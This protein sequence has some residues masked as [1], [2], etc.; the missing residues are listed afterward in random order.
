MWIKRSCGDRLENLASSRPVVLVTGAR[1]T[2]KSSL[3]K[4]R[5]PSLQYLTFDHLRQVE[6][7]QESPGLFLDQFNGPAVLDEIQYVP[8]L[9]KEI[10]PRVDLDRQSYGRWILTGSQRFELMENISESL[11]GRISIVNLETLSASELRGSQGLAVH[12]HLWKGG[13]PELWSNEN[14]EVDDFFESYLRTYVERDLKQII[15]VKNLSDF[16]RFMKI[17]AARTGQLLNYRDMANDVGI[18]D[19]TIKTWVHALQMSGLVYLLPPF[20]ANIGKRLTKSPKLYFADHGL[21]CYLLGINSADKWHSHIYRGNLWETFVLM[22]V[23]KTSSLVPG[24]ELFFYRDHNGVEIDF[25][26]EKGDDLT[27][28]EAKVGERIDPGKLNFRKVAPL[29]STGR[30]LKMIVAHN[31]GDHKPLPQKGYLSFNPLNSEPPI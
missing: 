16:R 23:V 26:V 22:E 28:I 25:L 29:L 12:E 2:G 1:Q 19:V 11:A 3:L 8:E 14:I 18:S 31:I 4:R 10:K 9:F 27:L 17:A 24:R 20:F 21:A 13:Y 30:N 7:A 15:D 5:F 6:A